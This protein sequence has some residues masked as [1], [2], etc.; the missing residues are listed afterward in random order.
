MDIAKRIRQIRKE[1]GL[2]QQEV[3][4]KL[5]MNRVQYNR[6]ETGKSDPTMYILQQI[7]NVLEANIVDFFEVTIDLVQEIHQLPL[8]KRFYIL[9]ETIKS[10]KKEEVQHQMELAAQELYDDYAND[11]ELTAFT[12]LDFEDFYEAK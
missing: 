1:K 8:A 10:I 4:D 3:A 9:E 7:A 11:K 5:S 2:S 6:I 12:S